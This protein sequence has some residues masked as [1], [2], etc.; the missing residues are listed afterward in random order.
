M[1]ERQVLIPDGYYLEVRYEFN[2]SYHNRIQFFDGQGEISHQRI[3]SEAVQG[4]G[5]W[6]R[7]EENTT[8]MEVT[9][10]LLVQHRTSTDDD[11]N[12]WIDDEELERASG[13]MPQGGRYLLLGYE[14]GGDNDFNDVKVAL[15]WIRNED[16]LNR[17]DEAMELLYQS[18]PEHFGQ[19]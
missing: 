16:R 17:V 11:D 7:S 15:Y 6:W 19:E 4:K 8:G 2:C 18:K 5:Y 14:D 10:S 12:N 9:S 1:S 13:D 3:S